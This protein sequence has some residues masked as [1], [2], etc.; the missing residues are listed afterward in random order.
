MEYKEAEK[1]TC[2]RFAIPGATIS[3]EFK[4]YAEEFSPLVDISRGGVKFLPLK[5]KPKS[6]NM[7]L[8]VDK[9]PINQHNI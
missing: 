9:Y 7:K 1:R 8:T 5:I 2:I 4:D 6:G 3:Y